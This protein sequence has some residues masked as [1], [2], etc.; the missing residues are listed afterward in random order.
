MG[1]NELQSAHMTLSDLLAK[2]KR[3][4]HDAINPAH[5]I[6]AEIYPMIFEPIVNNDERFQ[7]WAKSDQNFMLRC[8]GPPGCGKV[9]LKGPDL[10]QY[11]VH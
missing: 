9:A 11:T 4:L 10:N 2:H 3:S 1:S 8:V 6:G 5:E 7:Y